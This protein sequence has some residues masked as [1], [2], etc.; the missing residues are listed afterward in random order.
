MKLS[1]ITHIVQ[2]SITDNSTTI[3]TALGV[4]GTI[5]TAYLVGRAS[6]QAV[7]AIQIEQNRLDS[8][9]KSHPL[10]KKEKAKLVW[11][12]YIPAAASGILTI[13]CIIGG[14]RIGFKRTAAAYSLVTV[15]EKAFAEY[16]DKVVEQIGATK[17]Q[18]IKDQIAQD[19]VTATPGQNM[20]VVSS[21]SVL[22]FEM[23]TGRYFN[24]DMETL[25]KAQNT[26]NAKLIREV[27][28]DL[29]DFYYL[30][31]L[32]NTTTSAGVGW[33]S[34][35]MMELYFSTVMSEDNRPC[36]AFEYNY[37][38]MLDGCRW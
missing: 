3:L 25:R 19:R 6:F 22:C 24:C 17:E 18:K 15:S 5:S 30:V 38:K 33:D 11:K 26:I 12:L 1:K 10:D 36:I 29:N 21:G 23:H 32:P 28:A 16:K 2:K 7:E 34:D 14:T 37:V 8:Y 35:K 9:I 4:S 27:E 20:V 31:G 13:G